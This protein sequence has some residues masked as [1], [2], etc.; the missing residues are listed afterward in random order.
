MII[1]FATKL[2]LVL[3]ANNLGL[4]P[5]LVLMPSESLCLLC[6]FTWFPLSLRVCTLAL[7]LS[8]NIIVR[9]CVC[10]TVSV[11][12]PAHSFNSCPLNGT[13]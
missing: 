4:F 12:R 2:V 9:V 3:V 10:E 5:Y 7:L 8:G 6:V 11:C 13:L 1:S